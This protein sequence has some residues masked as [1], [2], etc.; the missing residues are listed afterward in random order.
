MPA[1]IRIPSALHKAVPAD[2]SFSSIVR[3]LL[4]SA[5]NDPTVV[6]NAMSSRLVF[7]KRPEESTGRYAIYISDDE[8][9]AAEEL[10]ELLLMSFNQL[11]QVLLEDL[12]FRAGRWMNE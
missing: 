8:K 3:E 4:T 6:I 2:V 1:V 7:K 12:L 5:V 11:V 10:A 9:K